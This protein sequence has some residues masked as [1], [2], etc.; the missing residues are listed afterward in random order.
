MDDFALGIGI[1]FI[2]AAI[3]AFCLVFFLGTIVLV[4][5]YAAL[6]RIKNRILHL[7]IILFAWIPGF[8]LIMHNDATG[9]LFGSFIFIAPF[10]VLIAVY[11]YPIFTSPV[12]QYKQILYLYAAVVFVSFYTRGFIPP[13]YNDLEIYRYILVSN[14]QIYCV[15]ILLDTCIALGI[16]Y[17][18]NFLGIDPKTDN[19]I[20]D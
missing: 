14:A 12:L 16:G 18:M 10:A 8:F 7:L 3:I 5:V 6:N 19:K 9:I 2:A 11:N 4:G 15:I 13:F 20:S 1:F 17:I